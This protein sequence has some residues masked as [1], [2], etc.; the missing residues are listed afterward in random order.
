[1]KPYSSFVPSNYHHFSLQSYLIQRFPYHTSEEWSELIA[2]GKVKVNNFDSKSELILLTGDEVAYYPSNQ[3]REEPPIDKDFQI[4][5]ENDSFLVV[6]KPPNI[7]VH[8]AGRYR[9]NTL[10]NLLEAERGIGSCYPVHRLDRET[11]GVM[12]FAKKKE[13]QLM[14]QSLFEKRQVSKKYEIL[15][16]GEFP[17]FLIADGFIGK[18]P[19]SQIR[20]KQLFSYTNIHDFKEAYTSFTKIQYNPKTNISHLLVQPKSGRIHQIRATLCSLNFP[21]VGD[22]LYGIRESAFIDF[23]NGGASEAL[24]LELGHSRQALHASEL[25]FEDPIASK[26]YHFKAKIFDDLCRFVVL[27]E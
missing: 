27:S 5:F 26:S 2:Q 9:T 6:N 7:P 23:A 4:I 25:E 20:K 3:N 17:D 1:M 21:V 24:T 16:F 18:D 22:K 19:N 8:P 11:S 15:V 13:Y 10:L 14:L 12:L